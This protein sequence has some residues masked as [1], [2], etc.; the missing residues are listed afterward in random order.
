MGPLPLWFNPSPE[1]DAC[2]SISSLLSAAKEAELCPESPAWSIRTGRQQQ[3]S[4]SHPQGAGLY[5]SA[6]RALL[7]HSSTLRELTCPACWGPQTLKRD[8][9]PA[10]LLGGTRKHDE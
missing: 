3:R 7:S 2:Q 10:G 4:L 5:N 8:P 1:A 9:C 6:T